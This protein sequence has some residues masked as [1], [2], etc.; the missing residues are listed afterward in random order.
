MAAQALLLLWAVLLAA[1]VRVAVSGP[2]GAGVGLSELPPQPLRAT[3][4]L[5]HASCDIFCR[6]VL[7]CIV[8]SA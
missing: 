2:E 7:R 8:P 3:K 1:S 6:T 4:A 5:S